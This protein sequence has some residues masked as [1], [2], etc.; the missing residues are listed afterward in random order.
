M[1]AAEPRVRIG[2]ILAGKTLVEGLLDVGGMGVMVA[3]QAD[4][5]GMDRT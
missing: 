1:N 3:P 2:E 4:P 5:F